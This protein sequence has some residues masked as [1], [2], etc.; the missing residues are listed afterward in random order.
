[1]KETS[2]RSAQ[3]G[4]E[5]EET[6]HVVTAKGTKEKEIPRMIERKGSGLGVEVRIRIDDEVRED[7]T[8]EEIE[9]S[10]NFIYL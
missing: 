10:R 6:D 5:T 3:N 8:G 1:M 9:V 2:M 7:K 4:K